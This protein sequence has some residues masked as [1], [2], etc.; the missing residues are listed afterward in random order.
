MTEPSTLDNVLKQPPFSIVRLQGVALHAIT[1]T[2]CV[3]FILDEL[4]AG[5]CGWVITMNISHLR[6]YAYEQAYRAIYVKASL[7]VA[8]GMPLIWASHLKGTPLPERV[9]GSNLIWSLSAAA[10]TQKRSIFLLGG[11]INTAQTTAKILQE[12][13]LGLDI[14]GIYYPEIGFENRPDDMQALTQAVVEAKPDIVYVALG[15][16]K[17]E[18]LIA[19]LRHHLPRTWWL[20][21]GASFSFV[22][23]HIPRAP[24]WMQWVGL[25]WF[26]RLALE[27]RRLS[28]RYLI[29]GIPF[30]LK[31]FG[32]AIFRRLTGN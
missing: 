2:Q 18:M 10:A 24:M 12:K 7:S 20:G 11:A 8:D 21:V 9:T 30:A 29:Q 16:T 27:P 5:R 4:D 22:S 23:G 31:L 25:E 6:R 14:A 1:E 15:S 32:D 19:Q 13:Y 17:Q 3:N 26:H 28:R